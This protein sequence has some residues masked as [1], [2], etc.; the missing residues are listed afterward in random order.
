VIHCVTVL[1]KPQH[2]PVSSYFQKPALNE[3]SQGLVK[4]PPVHCSP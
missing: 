4:K 2:S 3:M 1:A